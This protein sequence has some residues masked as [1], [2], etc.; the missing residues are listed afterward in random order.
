MRTLRSFLFNLILYSSVIPISITIIILFPFFKTSALQKIASKWI[1]FILYSLKLI[2]GVS[3]TIKG[4]E[5]LPDEPCILV[6]NHQGAW[7]SFFLQTLYFPSSSIIKEELLYIPFFGW[8]LACL[9][10]IHLKRSKKLVSLKKVI[11]D[12]SKK[13]ANGVSLII[14]PEG[15]RAR[16]HKGLKTFSNSCGLLSVKN[17]VPIIP[18]CHNSGLFWKNRTFNKHSGEIKVLIGAPLYGK[19]AKD[20][21]NKAFNWIEKNFKE[22]N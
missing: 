15:T 9:K 14:F 4:A 22:I 5:N 12:G 7:E 17:N 11:K 16:P 3:W 1:F 10:P 2:C 8:A 21:T 6:S 19:N 18:I 20:A 13:L